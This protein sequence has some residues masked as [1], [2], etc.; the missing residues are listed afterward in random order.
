MSQPVGR[1]PLYTSVV[2]LQKI[3]DKYFEWCDNRAVKR[4]DKE[5]NEYM[6]TDPAP[7]TM[8][9]LARRLGMSRETLVQYRDKTEFSDAIKEARNR[10]EEDIESRMN[11]KHTFTPGLIFNAKNNFGWKDK[12]ETDVTSGGK[13]ISNTIV[14]SNFK[15][16]SEGK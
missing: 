9:G 5:G 14:F 11:D 6:I 15:N 8:S 12:T 10:V 13:E 16:D 4:V 2:D 7:Y 1:P 3:I